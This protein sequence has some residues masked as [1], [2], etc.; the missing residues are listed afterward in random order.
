MAVGHGICATWKMLP[1]H[2]TVL[3]S[4]TFT[5]P[6]EV[7]ETFEHASMEGHSE[8]KQTNIYSKFKHCI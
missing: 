5:S 4:H 6:V 2:G 3:F 8:N 7:T 1:V